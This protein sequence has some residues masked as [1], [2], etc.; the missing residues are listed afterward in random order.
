MNLEITN[1][2][3]DDLLDDNDY[4]VDGLVD[5]PTL[6]IIRDAI[7]GDEGGAWERIR[8]IVYA[9]IQGT[10]E[11]NERYHRAMDELEGVA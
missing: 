8:K 4:L 10:E 2:I 9:Y 6:D 5:D 3:T 1:K 7:R 11:F